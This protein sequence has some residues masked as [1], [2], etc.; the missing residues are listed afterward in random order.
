MPKCPGLTSLWA[1]TPAVSARLR[2]QVWGAR[3]GACP[4][5]TY[6]SVRRPW[7]T[8]GRRSRPSMALSLGGARPA[9]DRLVVKRSMTSP[10]WWL[11]CDGR[12]PDALRMPAPPRPALPCPDGGPGP[13][14]QAC[15]LTHTRT[16]ARSQPTACPHTQNR[17]LPCPMTRVR[18]RMSAGS[19]PERG[20][21]PHA[22]G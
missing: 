14:P 5:G 12:G 6:L 11:T 4:A 19:R 3:R 22:P 1:R 20:P 21:R 13:G 15:S 9:R 7:S 8:V 16:H 17:G 18:G 10:S 2:H